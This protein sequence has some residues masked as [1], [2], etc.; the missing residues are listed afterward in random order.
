M[1]ASTHPRRVVI[2]G[3]GLISP[4]GN[5]PEAL[6]DALA[7]GR[8]GVA[9]LTL[10]PPLSIAPFG[11]EA[12][13][14]T[15]EIDGFGPLEPEKKKA[16]RK[17]LKVM[18]RESQMGVAA[19]QRAIADA[20]LQAGAFD[21]ER[22]G[23][24]YGSDYML[25]IP[26][27]LAGAVH[28]CLD[29]PHKFNFA[30]WGGEGLSKMQPLWLLKYLPNMPASHIAIYNDM[31]GPSNSITHR[32][33]ASNLAI[34]EALHIIARGHAE[35][36]IAGATGSR[37]HP[38]KAVHAAQTEEVVTPNCCP[39]SE[40]ARPFD[41]RRTGA[42][43]GEGAG[44]VV[45]EELSS[46]QR[47]GARIYAEVVGA[48]SSTVADRHLVGRR[49]EALAAAMRG[50]LRDA[51]ATP[52]EIGHIQAH[53]LGT[54]TSDIDESRALQNVFGDALPKLPVTAAKSYFGNLGAGSGAVELIAGVLALA[55]DR[56]FPI[57]NYRTPDPECPVHAVT[58]SETSPGASFLNLNVTPQGQAS[59]VMVRRWAG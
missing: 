5:T 14:F 47:R 8:S 28:A 2:T 56:L 9:P 35:V 59:C 25:S 32:E 48:A 45:L 46:A 6:W 33:A 37:L 58:H 29:E 3:L 53:G 52:A 42:V 49:D 1:P 51:G 43:L 15:G 38:M 27:E 50:T 12:R 40:A 57:L 7:N 24:V 10:T 11:G 21:P 22:T 17:G 41:L 31:R 18:C 26:D 44:V 30:R 54:R 4:L 36:M 23:V 34:G 19:A 16:I 13:E 39:P 55:N 20:G